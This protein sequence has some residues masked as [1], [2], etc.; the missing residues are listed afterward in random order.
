LS[1]NPK[2]REGVSG[3][4]ARTANLVQ[5]IRF[6]GV[7]KGLPVDGVERMKNNADIT[8]YASYNKLMD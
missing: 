8:H 5:T 4:A 1:G 6:L 2:E 3:E 7:K